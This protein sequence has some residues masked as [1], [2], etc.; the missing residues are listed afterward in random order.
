VQSLRTI[1]LVFSPLYIARVYT[2]RASLVALHHTQR[3]LSRSASY[4]HH[5]QAANKWKIPYDARAKVGL[6]DRPHAYVHHIIEFIHIW[7]S[8]TQL[9]G[10]YKCIFFWRTFTVYPNRLF[11]S[12]NTYILTIAFR[13]WCSC[14]LVLPLDLNGW[15]CWSFCVIIFDHSS[16]LKY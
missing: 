6:V 1:V 16:Y 12:S 8:I 13:I 15:C 9:G 3:S 4:Y 14:S 7:S 11:P 5:Q 2:E 10:P